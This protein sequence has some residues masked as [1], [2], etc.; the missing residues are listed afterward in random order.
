M[1]DLERILK[2]VA[3]LPKLRG[4]L[5]S[6]VSRLGG[7]Q[8]SYYVCW[9]RHETVNELQDPLNLSTLLD[10]HPALDGGFGPEENVDNYESFYTRGDW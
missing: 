5:S 2:G 10:D 3:R 4:L 8:E 9:S 1:R 6:R 7:W